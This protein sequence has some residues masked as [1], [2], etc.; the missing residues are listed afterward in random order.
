MIKIIYNK[1]TQV[2]TKSENISHRLRFTNE[3]KKRLRRLRKIKSTSR[4]GDITKNH[5]Y[6]HCLD[7]INVL[8]VSDIAS[9]KL[10]NSNHSNRI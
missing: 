6:Y 2:F 10:Q 7:E 8:G 1:G 3:K 9:T 5:L 4:I